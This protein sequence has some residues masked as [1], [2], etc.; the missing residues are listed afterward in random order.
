MKRIFLFGA[1]ALILFSCF[2]GVVYA[3]NQLDINRATNQVIREG[4]LLPGENEYASFHDELMTFDS[5]IAVGDWEVLVMGADTIALAD[6][7]NGGFLEI[8]VEAALS[9]STYGVHI[10]KPAANF[11]FDTTGKRVDI[12][13]RF[14]LS[15]VDSTYF[16]FGLVGEDSTSFGTANPADDSIGIEGTPA[17]LDSSFKH[18][19]IFKKLGA[20]SCLYVLNGRNGFPDTT[21]TSN[22]LHDTTRVAPGTYTIAAG[23]WF[24]L[25]IHYD[26]LREIRYTIDDI[27]VASHLD[28]NSVTIPWIPYDVPMK[29]I[30][31]FYAGQTA[32]TVLTADFIKGRQQVDR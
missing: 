23:K 12:Y 29:P 18:F 15:D 8:T 31:E 28:T 10:R 5:T 4:I 13:G 22:K 17:V 21:N 2:S 14:K 32:G 3:Q 9:D 16:V 19:A 27:T 6:S 24:K 30:V 11:Q 7:G 20:D 1:I 26:G 25:G